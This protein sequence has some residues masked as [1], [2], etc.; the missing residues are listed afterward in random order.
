[1][2]VA[3]NDHQ[4]NP[5]L[6]LVNGAVGGM[7]ASMI[8]DPDDHQTGTKYWNTVDERLKSAGATRRA[9]ASRSGSRRP[10][11]PRTRELFPST[12]V[13]WN[14]NWLASCKCCRI[15]LPT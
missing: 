11:P 7:S 5:R 14:P 2:E 3:E 10:I 8:Q 15:A 9:G 1:M 12:F 6:L 4:I 13:R